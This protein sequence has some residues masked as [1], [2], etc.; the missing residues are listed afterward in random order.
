MESLNHDLTTIDS[1]LLKWHMRLNPK[2]TKSMIISRSLTIAPGYGDLTLDDAELEELM[3]LR[4]LVVTL[5]FKLTFK[6]HMC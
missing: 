4:I 3:N 6:T 1:W 2:K 5:H